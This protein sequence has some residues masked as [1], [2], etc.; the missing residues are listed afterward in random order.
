M[1]RAIALGEGE[2]GW[3]RGWGEET[4]LG[5]GLEEAQQRGGWCRGR[6]FS[7]HDGLRRGSV[8]KVVLSL[9]RGNG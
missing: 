8:V 9:R 3:I 4:V 2:P 7:P 5:L 1:S 6:Q